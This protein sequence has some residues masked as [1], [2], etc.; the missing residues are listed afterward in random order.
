VKLYSIY[1]DQTRKDEQ[2]HFC[3]ILLPIVSKI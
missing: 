1:Q 3:P 2:V